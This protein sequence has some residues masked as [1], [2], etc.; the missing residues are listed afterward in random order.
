M[1]T[2]L[3]IILG[4][5]LAAACGFRIFVPMLLLS[6]AAQSG[7]VSLAHGF[8]WI[9]TMPALIAFAVATVI[10]ILGYLIPWVDNMLDAIT[11]PAAIVAGIV[12]TAASVTTIDPFLQWT[13]AIIAGGG[14]TGMIQAATGATRVVSSTTTGGAGNHL[15]TGAETGGSLL[16]A[17]S[18]LFLP[19]L[20]VILMCLALV[21]SFHFLKKTA[22][23]LYRRKT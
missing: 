13:L 4:L 1:D 10:E 16:M 11:T 9:G 14:V 19:I 15:I 20:A 18:A 2:A 21:G 22:A 6:I 17:F 23:P 3:S 12:V 7:H 5:G 8:A